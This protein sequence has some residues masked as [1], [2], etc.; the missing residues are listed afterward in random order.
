MIM[1]KTLFPATI[2]LLLIGCQHTQVSYVPV[3]GAELKV[4]VQEAEAQCKAE[5]TSGKDLIKLWNNLVSGFGK[6]FQNCMRIKG[7]ERVED[8]I[9]H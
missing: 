2:A 6:S 4:Q 1:R 8:P 5:I 3:S 7:F 9:V